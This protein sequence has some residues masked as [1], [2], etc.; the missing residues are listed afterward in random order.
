MM[1]SAEYKILLAACDLNPDADR[2]EKLRYLVSGNIDID[3][4]IDSAL[5]EGVAGLL[6][7]NLLKA[8]ALDRI[9]HQEG[10]R[11]QSI[12]YQ[13]VR[14]NLKLIHDLKAVLQALDREHIRVV[15]LQGIAL[16]LPVY[17]D[18][19]LR[20]M[21]DLD[22]WVLPGNYQRLADSL[23]RQGFQPE[24]VY[25]QTY[26]K[27]QTVIDIHTD[28]L[29]AER[30]KSRSS[31]LTGSQEDIYRNAETIDFEGEKALCLSTQDQV[32]RS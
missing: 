30:I 13:T 29:W 22:L 32:G 18:I 17:E 1:S 20:P 26:Q 14:L 3:Q 7:R 11:L 12:Y 28:I 15:L 10:Q 27:G 31:L 25:P 8:G 16:L 19:G 5:K 23:F 21:K 6:Y 9:G 24:P 2:L 4:L